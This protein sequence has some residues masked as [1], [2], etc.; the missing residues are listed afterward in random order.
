MAGVTSNRHVTVFAQN[1]SCSPQSKEIV[2]ESWEYC[3]D[4]NKIDLKRA[5]LDV[6]D[7]VDLNHG[8][9]QRVAFVKLLSWKRLDIF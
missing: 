4:D 1:L 7:G 8:Y 2:W 9:E 3:E 5:K 6:I